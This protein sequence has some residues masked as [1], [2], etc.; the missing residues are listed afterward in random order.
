MS[1]SI[2]FNSFKNE[3]TNKLSTYKPYT[4]IYLTVYK[5]D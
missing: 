3:I 1:L 2:S 5:H 4:L